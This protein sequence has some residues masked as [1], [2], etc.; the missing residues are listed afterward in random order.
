MNV[1]KSFWV[2]DLYIVQERTRPGLVHL[3]HLVNCCSWKGSSILISSVLEMSGHV[4]R[5]LI[6]LVHQLCP[7]L[8][9]LTLIRC[10]LSASVSS[11]EES[12]PS[13]DFL[14]FGEIPGLQKLRTKLWPSLLWSLDIAWFKIHILWLKS[15][16]H[17]IK[18]QKI[19]KQLLNF[20]WLNCLMQMKV[21]LIAVIQHT[22]PIIS[23]ETA[24]VGPESQ[25]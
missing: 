4:M 1:V 10:T 13:M 2:C 17:K 16:Q 3:L 19:Y 18:H 5:I 9:M 14:Q 24:P 7:W 20:F 11:N 22:K 21:P 25:G 8:C 12:A 6:V 15:S 23:G